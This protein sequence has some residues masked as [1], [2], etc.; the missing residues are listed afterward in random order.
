MAA[1]P[2][3]ELVGALVAELVRAESHAAFATLEFLRDAGFLG[4]GKGD[5]WGDLRFIHF[6][7]DVAGPDGRPTKR[8]IRV[9][10]LSLVPIPLQQVNEAE[11]DFNVTVADV[12]ESKPT[13]LRAEM[14]SPPATSGEILDIIG[15]FA[16]LT[17]SPRLREPRIHLRISMRQSDLPAGVSSTLRRIEE[18]SGERP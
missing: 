3:R 18:S 14:G 1:R 5:D 17:D 13:K 10:L 16:P 15:D 4:G 6:S 12:R 8:T 9:P 2:L 11:Y 7:F